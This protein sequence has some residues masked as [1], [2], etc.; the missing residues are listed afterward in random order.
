MLF[1][2]QIQIQ[3]AFQLASDQRMLDVS[4]VKK[5]LCRT[6]S[7]RRSEPSVDRASFN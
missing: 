3:K 2:R 4:F 6:V 7:V 1:E 5:S